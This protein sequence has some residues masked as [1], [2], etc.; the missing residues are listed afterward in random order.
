MKYLSVLGALVIICILLTRNSPVSGVQ[1]AVAEV[2]AI[3]PPAVAPA[4]SPSAATALKQPIDRTQAALQ[5]VKERN[6]D[7][8]F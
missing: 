8:E 4:P 3:A 5:Q 7:G 6:G 1:Q 2:D